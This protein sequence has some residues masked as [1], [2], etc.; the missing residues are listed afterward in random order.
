MDDTEDNKKNKENPDNKEKNSE[1]EEEK[2][3]KE[4]EEDEVLK[5]FDE[6]TSALDKLDEIISS[7]TGPVRPQRV[8][9]ILEETRSLADGKPNG[10]FNVSVLDQTERVSKYS[11]E[12][13]TNV[14]TI[15]AAGLVCLLDEACDFVYEKGSGYLE[16]RLRESDYD[17]AVKEV[18]EKN[19][20]EKASSSSSLRHKKGNGSD[21]DISNNILY[22]KDHQKFKELYSTK[23]FQPK[24]DFK[25]SKDQLEI[26]FTL[27]DDDDD[28]DDDD[29][30]N[31]DNN[32]N[33][34]K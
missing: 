16:D 7:L 12:Q 29:S 33:N 17:K 23:K 15:M 20:K 28:D 32:N 14:C 31:N 11:Q 25:S 19:K 21:P 5:R 9:L 4:K 18:A 3:G 2:D 13:E 8:F 22:F 34:D 30:N 10:G 26:N 24:V 27:D 1:E 6:A